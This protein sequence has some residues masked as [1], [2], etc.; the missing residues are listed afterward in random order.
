MS[1]LEIK[2]LSVLTASS[3]AVLWAMGRFAPQ[4]LPD[5]PGYLNIVGF[6]AML[7]EPRTPLYGWLVAALDVGRGRYIA[8]PAFQIAAYVA[9]VWLLTAQLRRYGLSAAAG[10][11]VGAALLFANALLMDAGWVHPELLSIAC[12]LAAFAGTVRLAQDKPPRWPWLAVLGGAAC[13]YVLRP[14]FLPLIAV[15]P[16]LY[17]A[18][19]LIR[20]EVLRGAR[21]GAIALVAA[22]PFL[23]IATLRAAIVGDPNIVSFGGFA[24]S[25]MATL[26]LS[27]EVV[28]RLPEDVKP[29]AA[30]VLAARSAGE[31]SGRFIGVPRNASNVR[32]FHSAALA[33]FDVLVR[34]YDNMV[35]EIIASMREPNESWVDFN[36]RLMQFS[37]AVVRAAPDRYAAW[38]V[39]GTTRTVGHAFATNLPA[40]LAIASIVILWPWRLFTRGQTVA[41]VAHMD[42][43]VMAVLAVL[44]FIGTGLLTMLVI[45]PVTRYI[46]TASVLV[47]PLFVYWAAL[48][49]PEPRALPAFTAARP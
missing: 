49:M 23:G 42:V 15:L 31:E 44:W 21:A 24:M 38:V 22:A 32:S 41:P 18:L 7:G 26:M 33:Y 19:R 27:D 12:A 39:G 29:F 17:L 35:V 34:T 45:A 14:S 30:R 2:A 4:L 16:A 28:A 47:A 9:G 6:P 10:L 1:R 40:A 43:P 37:L 46:E 25:G 11:S 13:A 5:T 8:V 20:G 36:R 48:L 3:L